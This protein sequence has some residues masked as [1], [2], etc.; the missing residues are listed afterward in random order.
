MRQAV[1]PHSPSRLPHHPTLLP[2][3]LSQATLAPSTVPRRNS[4]D[5]E[6]DLQCALPLDIHAP[7]IAAALY[8]HAR[9]PVA[10]HPTPYA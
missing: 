1:R 3:R 10:N 5:R 6:G 7:L 9:R 2:F 4:C 8:W